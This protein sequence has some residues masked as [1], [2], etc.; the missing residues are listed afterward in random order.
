MPPRWRTSGETRSERGQQLQHQATQQ[1]A[2]PTNLNG[3]KRKERGC[4]MVA[5][6][7]STSAAACWTAASAGR[8]ARALVSLWRRGPDQATKSNPLTSQKDHRSSV[9]CSAVPSRST[10]S[11]TLRALVIRLQRVRAFTRSSGAGIQIQE[12]LSY[13]STRIMLDEFI[14]PMA[15]EAQAS[16]SC[17]PT[18]G[19]S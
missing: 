4:A 3:T 18:H 8:S 19:H 14:K 5:A 17:T 6:V 1:T 15:D 7:S 12:S 10:G 16:L 2:P 13:D 9:A 11:G